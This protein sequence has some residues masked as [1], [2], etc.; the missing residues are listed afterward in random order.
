MLTG[1]SD[2]ATNI[3][4]IMTNTR[5]ISSFVSRM[6]RTQKLVKPHLDSDGTFTSHG[7]LFTTISRSG[8]SPESTFLSLLASRRRIDC[9]E[10]VMHT[11]K[12]ELLWCAPTSNSI[13]SLLSGASI[14]LS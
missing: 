6:I 13:A 2:F 1:S 4:Q 8:I 7:L 12:T 14:S 9:C 3:G 10:S 5:E 11:P